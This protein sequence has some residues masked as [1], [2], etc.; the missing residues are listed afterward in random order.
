MADKHDY[1]RLEN[2]C[3]ASTVL[4]PKLCDESPDVCEYTHVVS[5]DSKEAYPSLTGSA[6]VKLEYDPPRPWYT[7]RSRS[8]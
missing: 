5:L 6:K 3:T 4:S 2:G 7:M 1:L 8:G